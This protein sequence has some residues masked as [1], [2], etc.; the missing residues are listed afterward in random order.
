VAHGYKPL[1]FQCSGDCNINVACDGEWQNEIRSVGL[2]LTNLG[3]RFCSG[4][5][6]NN[7]DNNGDQLFLTAHHCQ[8]DGSDLVMFLYQSE[9][10]S[11]D[12]NG[13]TDNIV[14]GLTGLARDPHTDF[15]L[16][17]IREPIPASW[18]VYL[19]GISGDNVA[20]QSLVGIHHPLG[21]VK[22]IS[23]AYKPGTPARWV[24]S[25]PGD[26]HWRVPFWDRGTT[27]RGSSGSPLFD[28]NRRVVGQLHGG[29]ASCTVQ[30]WD[31][32]GA[33][34]ASWPLGLVTFLDPSHTG[35]LLIDGADL[36]AVR[37]M[38]F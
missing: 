37:K 36:N 29:P 28:Q 6:V 21:D 30:D 33:A 13:P 35:N 16:M 7:A 27:E 17:R 8:A 20:P 24:G 25:E 2:L 10:C 1:C 26:W 22:K 11:P 14:G 18:N 38:T 19:S 23:Y 4:S 34:W 31:L 3:R 15:L 9:T 12:T 32:Y 5:L